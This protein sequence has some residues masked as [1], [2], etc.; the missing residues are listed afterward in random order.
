VLIVEPA[1]RP[2]QEWTYAPAQV[3]VKV[4]TNVDW[5]NTGAVAHTVTADDGKSFDSGSIDPH[6][7][8]TLSPPVAGM[9]AY[10]CSFHLWMTGELTVTQ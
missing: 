10:H 1:F 6:A 4:G 9:F 3:S 7:S 2:P 8:F 5:T